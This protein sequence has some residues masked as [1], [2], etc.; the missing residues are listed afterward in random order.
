MEL[1]FSGD[2]AIFDNLESLTFT[3]VRTIGNE[4]VEVDDATFD[5]VT[6]KEA[7]ASNGVYQAGDV[8]FSIRQS[9]LQQLGGAKPG[10]RVLRT[11]DGQTYTVLTAV[12]TVF[13]KI[14][15]L[16]CRNLILANDL[17]QTGTLSRP[18]NAQDAAGRP[19]LASYTTVAADIPCRVQPMGGTAGDVL[20]RRTIA[21]RFT[22][23][24]GIQVEARAKDKFVVAGV[25]YT[26]LESKN[27]ERID[28]LQEL[29]LE[30]VL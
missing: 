26:V 20:D 4:S 15:D 9:L 7:A 13:T 18:S 14:W 29:T 16:V 12:P 19:T 30:K 23:F 25:T 22:A 3:S 5:F 6:L 21:N 1:D 27:P 10:D 2:Q 11:S 17:R 28:A 24:L 8:S